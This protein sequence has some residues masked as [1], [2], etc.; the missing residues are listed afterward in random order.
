MPRLCAKWCATR[1]H[2]HA[3]LPR[4]FC[5][6][7]LRKA[8]RRFDLAADIHHV[9]PREFARHPVVRRYGYDVESGY[10]LVLLPTRAYDGARPVHR[11]GHRQYNDMVRA[12]LDLCTT[13]TLFVF[14]LCLLHA[15]CRGRIRLPWR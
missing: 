3:L 7:R 11:G 9:V 1:C 6:K 8:R 14:F 15:G 13:R 10:N 12:H 4:G 2:Y 5:K